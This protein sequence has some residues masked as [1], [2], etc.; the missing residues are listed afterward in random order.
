MSRSRVSRLSG[1][2]TTFALLIALA[3]VPA[4]ATLAVSE[5]AGGPIVFVGSSIFHRWTA[6]SSQMAPLPIVNIAFDG[7][8]TS[9]MLRLVD[10]RVVSYKPRVVAY[11]CGS[12]DVD[13]GEEGTAIFERIQQFMVRTRTALPDVRIVF[14]SIIRAP[15]KQSRWDVVDDVNRRVQAYAA[16]RKG[17]EFVDVNPLVFTAAGMPRFDLYLSDQLHFRPKAYEAFAAALK[18]VLANA[19]EKP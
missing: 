13:A 12:N 4:A 3:I 2:S 5:A 7:A 16:A 6:L 9:D 1:V 11:Y 8:Q 15:E 18:P 17:I 19:F 10:S 14:V